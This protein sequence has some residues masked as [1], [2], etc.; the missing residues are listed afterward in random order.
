MY[1]DEEDVRTLVEGLDS[2][3]I[4]PFSG[5][6]SDLVA[7]SSGHVASADVTKDLEAK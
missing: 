7:I 4:N 5:E 1:K 2:S 6:Q 3:W